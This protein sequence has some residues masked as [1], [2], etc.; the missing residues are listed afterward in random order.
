MP[1]EISRC[2]GH[3]CEKFTLPYTPSELRKIY[4]GR[5]KGEIGG[6]TVD[7]DW[8]EAQQ[9][10]LM[11]K[12]IMNDYTPKNPRLYTCRNFD[13]T[14]RNCKIYDHR[15]RMCRNFPYGKKCPN[16]ECTL[17]YEKTPTIGFTEKKFEESDRH[18]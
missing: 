1:T 14:T 9:I 8:K 5:G 11:V 16:K 3:C 4:E 13:V 6:A 18:E 2:T 7:I 17:K 10:I 15:P 12:S